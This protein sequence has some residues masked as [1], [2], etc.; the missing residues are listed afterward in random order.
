MCVWV[1]GNGNGWRGRSGESVDRSRGKRQEEG[2]RKER[3]E[4]GSRYG[5]RDEERNPVSY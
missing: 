4:G 2:E 1:E 5:S 3:V